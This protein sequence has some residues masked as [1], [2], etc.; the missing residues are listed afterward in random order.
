MPLAL[1]SI[2]PTLPLWLEADLA[3]PLDLE[4]SYEATFVELR[5]P[6]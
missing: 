5:V 1:G 2:L 3:V 4:R 6:V